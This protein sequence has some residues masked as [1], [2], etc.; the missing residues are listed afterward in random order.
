MIKQLSLS[1]IILVLF[2]SFAFAYPPLVYNRKDITK[3]DLNKFKVIMQQIPE[4]YFNGIQAITIRNKPYPL[5]ENLSGYFEFHSYKTYIWIYKIN[6]TQEDLL[7]HILLHELGHYKQFKKLILRYSINEISKKGLSE[8][9][10]EDFAI[11]NSY[12][13]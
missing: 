5:N 2:S 8:R 4:D 13:C 11:N 1:V 3:G 6:E 10:A 12:L 7:C 9:Y